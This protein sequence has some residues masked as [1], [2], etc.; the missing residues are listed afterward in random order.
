MDSSL[1]CA[2]YGGRY[3]KHEGNY[4]GKV[5]AQLWVKAIKQANMLNLDSLPD[6][7]AQ[8]DDAALVQFILYTSSGE[9]HFLGSDGALPDPLFKLYI[10]IATHE[11]A[12]TLRPAA[13]SIHFATY[14]QRELPAPP[15]STRR[16]VAPAN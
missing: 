3:A 6:A 13:N 14:V 5:G 7:Y 10:W 4:R 1:S 16:S 2:Y 11:S 8:N 12:L 15:I 9:K